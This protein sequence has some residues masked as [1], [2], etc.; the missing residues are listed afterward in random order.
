MNK[1]TVL[2]YVIYGAAVA[3]AGYLIFIPLKKRFGVVAKIPAVF[4]LEKTIVNQKSDLS[5]QLTEVAEKMNKKNLLFH[6]KVFLNNFDEINFSGNNPNFLG[7]TDAGKLV[8]KE[9]QAPNSVTPLFTAT[10]FDHGKC[11]DGIIALSYQDAPLKSLND[12]NQKNIAVLNYDKPYNSSVV[13]YELTKYAVHPAKIYVANN[14]GPVIKALKDGSVSYMLMRRYI[15]DRENNENFI[16]SRG[17]K[18]SLMHKTSQPC[19]MIY[20]GGTNPTWVKSV[21]QN[22]NIALEQMNED[23]QVQ[24]VLD[25]DQLVPITKAEFDGYKKIYQSGLAIHLDTVDIS[26]TKK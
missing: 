14:P 3:A 12:L 11:F 21:Q 16:S 22:L 18:I 25:I 10:Q 8:E 4:Y 15:Y 1:S 17:Y 23:T 6:F 26:D 20:V 9:I 2:S 13:N 7:L 24:K 5:E 19:R